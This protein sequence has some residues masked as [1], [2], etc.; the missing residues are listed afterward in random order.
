MSNILL[1]AMG[2]L[3]IVPSVIYKQYLLTLTFIIF[4]L[5]FGFVEFLADYYTGSTVT[6]HMQKLIATNNREAWIVLGCMALAWVCLL[7]HL[8]IRFKK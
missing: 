3:F 4:G 6:Q 5:V 8:G 2:I 1:I 7:L